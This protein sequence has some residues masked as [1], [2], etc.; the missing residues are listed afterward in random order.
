[1]KL[2]CYLQLKPI[3]QI[4]FSSSIS[5]GIKSIDPSIIQF[6]ADNQSDLYHIK[7]GTEF[8]QESSLILLHLDAESGENI[9]PLNKLLE[10]IRKYK[11]PLFVIWEGE[12]EALARSIK[13]LKPQQE[14]QLKEI[15]WS[16]LKGFLQ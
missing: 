6:E 10:A 12:H 3:E 16:E 14:F 13:M 2:Y 7:R 4:A 9:G 1:M 11:K 5:E 8:I 15:D